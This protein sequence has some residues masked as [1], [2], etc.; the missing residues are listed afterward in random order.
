M[1]NSQDNR[2]AE[3]LEKV[4]KVLALARD[5][6]GNENEKQSALE[7]ANRLMAAYGIAEAEVDMKTIDQGD[8]IFGECMAGPDGKAPERGKVYRQCPSWAGILAVGVARFTD[9]IVIRKSTEFGE[10]LVFQGEK[11]GNYILD[12]TN[13]SIILVAYD[14]TGATKCHRKA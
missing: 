2:R 8:M 13:K 9:S 12:T 6:S 1:Q 5:N 3:M 14:L 11:N 10:V 7:H 4:R